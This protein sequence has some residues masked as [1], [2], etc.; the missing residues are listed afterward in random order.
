VLCVVLHPVVV[1]LQQG[2]VTRC[3]FGLLRDKFSAGR[4]GE[5]NGLVEVCGKGSITKH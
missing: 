3:F 5:G 4:F 2:V 1:F